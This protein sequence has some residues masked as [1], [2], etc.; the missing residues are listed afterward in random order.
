[1][2]ISEKVTSVASGMHGPV[3]PVMP[4]SHSNDAQHPI[5]KLLQGIDPQQRLGP[6]VREKKNSSTIGIETRFRRNA[7]NKLGHRSGRLWADLGYTLCPESYALGLHFGLLPGPQRGPKNP[8]KRSPKTLEQV[9]SSSD[10]SR[11]LRE[12][13][14][15]LPLRRLASSE[16]RR[17]LHLLFP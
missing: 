16:P 11:K 6:L 13:S 15:L 4:S 9:L 14:P 3:Q 1:M 17:P 12:G 10:C 5:A 7:K 8:K 2:E